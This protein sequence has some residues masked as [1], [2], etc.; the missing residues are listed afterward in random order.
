MWTCPCQEQP[1]WNLRV[2]LSCQHQ[3][4]ICLQSKRTRPRFTPRAQGPLSGQQDVSPVSTATITAP[5]PPPSPV[6]E[7]GI[8]G[9]TNGSS[10]KVTVAA[11]DIG[12]NSFHLVVGVVRPDTSG[13]GHRRGFEV[14]DQVINA[15][16][17]DNIS[18]TGQY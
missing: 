3:Q 17:T 7:S 11:I 16:D 13:D 6:V 1:R 9:E 5:L 8:P 14:I 4:L 18:L 10:E 15:H 12:T 2:S